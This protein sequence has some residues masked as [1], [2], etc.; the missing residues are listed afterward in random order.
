MVRHAVQQRVAPRGVGHACGALLQQ[1][2]AGLQAAPG[3]RVALGVQHLPAVGIDAQRFFDAVQQRGLTALR[4]GVQQR[5]HRVDAGAR[6]LAVAAGLLR[7]SQ[8]GRCLSRQLRQA[9]RRETI[10]RRLQR[11]QRRSVFTHRQFGL[12]GNAP[13][14]RR[15]PVA[16]HRVKDR[17]RLPRQAQRVHQLAAV[18]G[19]QG[20][21]ELHR[22]RAFAAAD[23]LVARQ[24]FLKTLG[25]L[26]VGAQTQLDIAQV[27]EHIAFMG[28]VAGGP[29]AVQGLLVEA[30]GSG[31][32]A[33]VVGVQAQGIQHRAFQ[34][35]VLQAPR[36]AQQFVGAVPEFFV[37]PQAAER[38][39]AVAAG[40]GRQL[41]RIGGRECL[42]PLGKRQRLLRVTGF[43]VP[44]GARVQH[45]AAPVVVVQGFGQCFQRI[46][47]G[48]A[49]SV[50]PHQRK[51][52]RAQ[53]RQRVFLR[54]RV[55][56][57]ARLRVGRQQRQCA[58]GMRQRLFV[59]VARLRL[60]GRALPRGQRAR[61]FCAAFK[62]FGN[63]LL[64]FVAG[65]PFEPV[66]H[67]RVRRHP[68][69]LQ[70]PFIADALQ[71]VVA[72]AVFAPPFELAGG[73]RQHELAADQPQQ[74]G[75]GLQA[76]RLQRVVPE[77][78]THHGRALQHPRFGR[79]QPVQTRLQHAGERARQR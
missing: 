45:L 44:L 36:Q 63:L 38:V 24:H 32:V 46:Q 53:Q 55:G 11:H 30:D 37:P 2:P 35:F 79:A 8:A 15:Q 51:D 40:A 57:C 9:Q 17:Q 69:A 21:V 31:G 42:G 7:Q 76:Q 73:A 43:K 48:D 47:L 77:H 75:V 62:V 49:G 56:L 4:G 29:V 41:G 13:R 5:Q 25:R 67:L 61:R 16:A 6:L 74:R 3:A 72:K 78:H 14:C 65:Q 23:A 18:H 54:Q 71:Q 50:L 59:G 26:F 12:P 68:F 1:A 20:Q 19:R 34:P 39:G 66:R 70:Q 33:A 10:A 58:C 60:L 64:R 22:G 27:V 28:L 52:L